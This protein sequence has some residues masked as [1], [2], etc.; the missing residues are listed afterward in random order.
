MKIEPTKEFA[1]KLGIMLESKLIWYKHFHP[2]CDDVIL[3]YEKPPYWIIEL[4]TVKYQGDAI[5]I[6]NRY[7][8]SEP[9]VDEYLNSLH[10]H[11]IACLYM[12]YDRREISWASFLLGSGQYADHYQAVK[13]ECEYFYELLNEYEAEE[14]DMEL[15]HKQS[16]EIRDMFRNEIMEMQEIYD[17]FRNYFKQ[18][19][20]KER[21]A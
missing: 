18:Y 10:D 12:K 8:H 15:E 20:R 9:F 4:A 13:V 7:I 16:E 2:F 17:V 19:I 21:E 14:F 5:G 11:Y 1:C 6:V 3:E